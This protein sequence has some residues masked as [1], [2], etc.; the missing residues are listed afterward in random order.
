MF[1]REIL[2]EQLRED[3][4]RLNE[5]VLRVANGEIWLKRERDMLEGAV[6]TKMCILNAQK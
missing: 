1:D 2:K 5:L 3:F 6:L 4:E